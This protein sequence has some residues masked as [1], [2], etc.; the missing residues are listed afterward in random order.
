MTG[1]I[2]PDYL[3]RIEYARHNPEPAND[4]MVRS[5]LNLIAGAGGLITEP[6]T[7][8]ARPRAHRALAKSHT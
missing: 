6:G 4:D 8:P 7:V 5:Q 2:S 1:D 3:D